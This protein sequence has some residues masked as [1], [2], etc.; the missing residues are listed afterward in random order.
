MA[1]DDPQAQDLGARLRGQSHVHRFGGH[2]TLSEEHQQARLASDPARAQVAL[3]IALAPED[4]DVS[5]HS[6][7]AEG[8]IIIQEQRLR[9]AF[10]PERNRAS[11]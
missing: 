11:S 4:Q 3:P 8:R 2:N 9:T 6:V 1:P 5:D 7:V 10:Q